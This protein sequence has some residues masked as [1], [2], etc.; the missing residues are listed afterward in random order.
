MAVIGDQN[1]LK[2]ILIKH[3]RGQI[4][5][6]RLIA[7]NWTWLRGRP[8]SQLSF[9]RTHPKCLLQLRVS[10]F[11]PVPK[12]DRGGGGEWSAVLG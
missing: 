7:E 5:R 11:S 9:D 12:T 3:R 2:P 8:V 6:Q 10:G 1:S 4:R